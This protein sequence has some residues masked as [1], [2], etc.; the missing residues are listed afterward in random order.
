MSSTSTVTPPQ[1][2]ANQH[3]YD[4]FD[5]AFAESFVQNVYSLLNE[6]YF[7]IQFVGFDQPIQRNNS[8]AP[9]I[10]A[11]NHSGMALPW[12]A[13]AFMAGLLKHFDYDHTK[14][15][16]ALIAPALS[17]VGVLIPFFV[18]NFWKKCGGID[19]TYFNFETMMHHPFANLLIYPEGIAGIGKGFSKRYQ[20]QRLSTSFVRMSL[21]YDTDIV[22]FST[23]NG[24]YVNPYMYN[25]PPINWLVR[26]LTGIPFL[27]MG[28][29]TLLLLFQPWFL[30]YSFPTKLTYVKGKRIKRKDLSEKSFS[31][32]SEDEI[33]AIRDEIHQQMQTELDEAVRNFGKQPFK[34]VEFFKSV[35]RKRRYFPFI[36]PFGWPLLFSEFQRQWEK[37]GEV[38]IEFGWKMVIRLFWKKPIVLA[39]FVPVLGW[40]PI[41]WLAKKRGKVLREEV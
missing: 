18:P 36:F 20:L 40:L 5:P 31:E 11:S 12:D 41:I 14:V 3:I 39:Y 6:I 34:I 19:A 30:Y 32:I 1:I 38:K 8:D 33:R 4:D 37:E 24:E 25:I 21:K 17:K 9:V 16:R 26:R 10:L 7:R 15:C 29:L 23:V 22:P 2:K 13:T 27:P 35:W 28:L